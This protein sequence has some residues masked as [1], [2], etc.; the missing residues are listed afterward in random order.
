MTVDE[1]IE[2]LIQKNE[3]YGNS[4][5]DPLRIFSSLGPREQLRVR[6]DDKLSRIARG[7]NTDRVPEDTLKDLVGYL[8]L[9]DIAERSWRQ[10]FAAAA[11]ISGDRLSAALADEWPG[12]PPPWWTGAATPS[13]ILD[14]ARYP[15]SA[16]HFAAWLLRASNRCRPRDITEEPA[17]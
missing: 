10:S 7:K 11:S 13:A 6:I 9:L 16:I 3:A 4:A 2:M 8:V 15:W 1:I 12:A 5:L 14:A 17:Q